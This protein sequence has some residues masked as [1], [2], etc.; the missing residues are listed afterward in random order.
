MYFILKNHYNLFHLMF[1]VAVYKKNTISKYCNLTSFYEVLYYMQWC[2]Q[3]WCGIAL[4][5]NRNSITKKWNVHLCMRQVH[6][7][8]AK[9]EAHWKY[10]NPHAATS[11]KN[12][13]VNY[14]GH[15]VPCRFY[16]TFY[17]TL[18]VI[19]SGSRTYVTL[20]SKYVGGEVFWGLVGEFSAAVNMLQ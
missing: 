6:S 20:V 16:P 9:S 12:F 14:L 11:C 17:T 7:L 15:R 2:H 8:I 5:F 10:I 4:C 1:I 18:G 13:N 19:N 3:L